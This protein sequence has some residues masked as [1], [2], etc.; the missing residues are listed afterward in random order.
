MHIFWF[1]HIISWH[2]YFDVCI[3]KKKISRIV[4][5]LLLVVYR[6]ILS[7]EGN[8]AHG[9]YLDVKGS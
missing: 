4:S 1:M 6:G 7:K 9:S 8:S 3:R 5:F 2:A